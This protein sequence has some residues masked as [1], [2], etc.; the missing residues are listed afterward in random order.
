MA[1][2]LPGLVAHAVELLA[3]AGPVRVV[4][5]FGGHGLYVDGLFVAIVAFDRL[6]LKA[7]DTTVARFETAGASP[8]VYEGAGR[9][10]ALRYFSAPEEAMESP[11]GMQPWIRL[12]IEAALRARARR[13]A[14]RPSRTKA[15]PSRGSGRQR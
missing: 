4:A 3:P 8:F 6:W 7:D 2:P 10:V 14:A 1:R 15:R 11:A 12:A 13:P 5:M 9:T